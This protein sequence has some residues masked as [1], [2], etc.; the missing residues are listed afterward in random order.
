MALSCRIPS[1]LHLRVHLHL[2]L[3][4]ASQLLVGS[5]HNSRSKKEALGTYGVLDQC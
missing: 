5:C 1:T 4:Q 3:P 2:H